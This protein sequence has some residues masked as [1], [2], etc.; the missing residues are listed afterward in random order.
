MGG[1]WVPGLSHGT[2]C[3]EKAEKTHP[4]SMMS[5]QLY[6][7][8]ELLCEEGARPKGGKAALLGEKTDPTQGRDRSRATPSAA[9][10]RGRGCQRA[11]ARGDGD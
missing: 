8:Q 3:T 7:G 1:Y 5:E 9:Q 6:L 10:T 4:S 2:D 11:A